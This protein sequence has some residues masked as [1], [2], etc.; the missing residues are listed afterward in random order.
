[1]VS[2]ATYKIIG[3]YADGRTRFW[4]RVGAPNDAWLCSRGTY[5]KC[6]A[7]I[8]YMPSRKGWTVTDVRHAQQVVAIHSGYSKWAGYVRSPRIFPTEEAATMFAIHK[9]QQV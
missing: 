7:M 5:F 2:T 1:M 3:V 9:L 4:T 6:D 8:R